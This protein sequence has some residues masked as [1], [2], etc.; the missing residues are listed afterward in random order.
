VHDKTIR[1]THGSLDADI[2]LLENEVQ[3]DV[4]AYILGRIAD[5]TWLAISYVPDIAKIR[6]KVSTLL[7]SSI[8]YR[9]D[10]VIDVIRLHPRRTH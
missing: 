5:S 3:P 10:N 8:L 2:A 7:Y 4:P 9:T 1:G 6:D